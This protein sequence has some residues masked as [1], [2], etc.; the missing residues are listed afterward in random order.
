MNIR[1][2]S[3]VESTL[4][5]LIPHTT[6]RILH[7]VIKQQKT[8]WLL[9]QKCDSYSTKLCC[10]RNT[11]YPTTISCCKTLQKQQHNTIQFPHKL[12]LVL[13][14]F[15]YEEYHGIFLKACLVHKS[16]RAPF[17]PSNTEFGPTFLTQLRANFLSSVI[18]S[19]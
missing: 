3:N 8:L 12:C 6:T 16:F 2:T 11:T 13:L 18:S 1:L 7:N 9:L 4:Y 14:M 10:Y 19:N 15:S 5:R 17:F